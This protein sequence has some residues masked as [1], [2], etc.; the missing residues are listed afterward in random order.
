MSMLELPEIP[1]VDPDTLRALE[2]QRD[3][4]RCEV[5][6]RADELATAEEDLASV[7]KKIRE[8]DGKGALVRAAAEHLLRS[9]LR[10][11]APARD[12]LEAV[13]GGEDIHV[14]RGVALLYGVA[15]PVDLWPKVGE[16]KSERTVAR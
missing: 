7:E 10:L 6:R 13:E 16:G 4:A 11:S 1:P 12:A 14:V 2:A 5:A 15:L 9:D 3:D 8:Q